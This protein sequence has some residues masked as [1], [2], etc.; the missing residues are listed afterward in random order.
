MDGIY[1]G[2]DIGSSTV[3]VV[4]LISENNTLNISSYLSYEHFNN[5]L[6]KLQII[7]QQ[8]R[9]KPVL[10]IQ[11]TGLMS[12]L[13]KLP[14]IPIKYARLKGFN[15]LYKLNNCVI[16]SFGHKSNSILEIV[17]DRLSRYEENYKC[18]QGSG[19]F[20]QSMLS[21]FNTPI[22][23]INLE[24]FEGER[25]LNL[26]GRCPVLLKS[27]ITHLHN[28]GES[29]KAILA[30]LLDIISENL[31]INY[32]P[33]PKINYALLTGGIS[34]VLRIRNNICS[35]LKTHNIQLISENE[36]DYFLDAFGCALNAFEKG[37]VEINLNSDL[38]NNEFIHWDKTPALS[39]YLGKVK[40][41]QPPQN[42]IIS[43]SDSFIAGLDIGST[44]SKLVL[45]EYDTQ[46]II[47]EDYVKTNGEPLNAVKRLLHNLS[48]HSNIGTKIICF[49]VTGSGRFLIESILKNLFGPGQVFVFNEIVAHAKGALYYDSAVDTIFEIGGQDSKYIRLSNGAI[50]D[51]AL[52]DACSAGT[53]S[54]LEELC[55]R[56]SDY[57][58]LKCLN[59][60]VLNA[61][62]GI[63]L[64]Q[65]CSVFISDVIERAIASGCSKESLAVGL[66]DSVIINYL[67][68]VKKN[69]TIGKK[70][71]CQ[72]MPFSMEALACSVARQT[73]CEIIIPNNPGTI[74][75]LGA[76]LLAKSTITNDKKKYLN[77]DLIFNV[78]YLAKDNF[79]CK[80]N[81][82]CTQ[83]G[84]R[85]L[86]E[87][88]IIKQ[89][90]KVEELYWGGNCA[91]WDKQSKKTI[92]SNYPN[93]FLQ[94][95]QLIERIKNNLKI[96]QE[97]KTVAITDKFDLVELFP[98]FSSFFSNLGFNIIT[99][100]DRPESLLSE[101]KK[102][103]NV[104]LCSPA[105]M[106]IGE[107]H[108]LIKKNPDYLF[109]PIFI[110]S[111][112][113]LNNKK[114]SNCPIVQCNSYLIK[115]SINGNHKSHILTPIIRIGKE[116]IYSKEFYDSCK[117]ITGSMGISGTRIDK[118]YK[119]AIEVQKNFFSDCLEI[120][121][122]AI[123]YCRDHNII[124]VIVLGKIYSLHNKY[125]NSNVPDYLRELDVIPIP[126]DCYR[127]EAASIDFS[128]IYWGYAQQ[129]LMA[130]DQ[131][132]KQPDLFS[133]FC[134]NYSC[135]PDSFLESYYNYIMDEKPS[136]IIENDGDSG[137]I[138]T[139][140][141][142]EIFLHCINEHK[143]NKQKKSEKDISAIFKNTNVKLAQLL[144]SDDRILLP[145]IGYSSNAVAAVLRGSGIKCEALPKPDSEAL[146]LGKRF[147][148]GKE[149]LPM[150]I[151]IG[152]L[153]HYIY[154]NKLLEQNNKIYYF[155]PG[156][157]G[158]CRFG[159]YQI[160]DKLILN[161]LGLQEKVYI[162]STGDDELFEGM[163]SS[164]NAIIYLALIS[165]DNLV[166]C[167]DFVR[168]VENKS[169]DTNKLFNYYY[170]M[171]I[172]K[173]ENINC[174]NISDK[175]LIVEILTRNL[176]G[177]AKLFEDVAQDYSKLKTSRK[178]KT[179]S[180]DGALYVR[181]DSFTNQNIA[182]KLESLGLRIK[183]VPFTE[184]LDFLNTFN[185]NEH[186]KNGIKNLFNDYLRKT[187]R[188]I[189]NSILHKNLGM[190]KFP[191]LESKLKEISPF[192][193]SESVG[194]AILSIG[195]SMVL[196]K[197]SRIDGIINICPFECLQCKVAD[198]I[199]K[200]SS[201]DII[202]KSIEFN[203]D[204][205]NPNLI[206]DFVFDVEN[207]R[208][209]L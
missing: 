114:T 161:N 82:G 178:V 132:S 80:S 10:G 65:H 187:I 136:L 170:S 134:S 143:K 199:V 174:F 86:I 124:P 203:E 140:T 20:L 71:F 89:K 1:L 9:T 149:C 208:K 90:E 99:L 8:E 139:K 31:L 39:E 28:N 79:L 176:F 177:F 12:D 165:I 106:N 194:E 69:R 16:I 50:T 7:F 135:G 133:A 146:A 160:L 184:W 166:A 153:L 35:L 84:N 147:T 96:I 3:K 141:R 162:L 105:L 197:K 48:V 175:K 202:T 68:R 52:N 74:G 26:P 204:P 198:S 138:G 122:Y 182:Q 42:D 29:K 129:V 25:R 207:N 159:N 185:D 188:T 56:F 58:D 70:I 168:P 112:N 171:I 154:K 100:E 63:N 125:L 14:S 118:A 43:K 27:S 60:T 18:A 55:T 54:F 78:D 128:E 33:N 181:L 61:E 151:T 19:S 186:H 46:N 95:K 83:Q 111:I 102:H 49:A 97:G 22:H 5:P 196:N 191:E 98:F 130:S 51:F 66:F 23:K 173:L 156:S 167:T 85:C 209:V 157:N 57:F 201:T 193:G 127:L 113:Y 87:K 131:I 163:P 38:L 11:V 93:P 81:V 108:S 109:K 120:G 6:N 126:M 123:K 36:Q 15:Y 189:P 179:I 32:I 76:S 91:L 62:N 45:I 115:N 121:D 180:L 169:G 21:R 104:T 88:V 24:N 119:D 17:D 2:I 75:A 73:G 40:R 34:K 192:I 206:T 200:N 13:I 144:G 41:L 183:H 53:G 137:N 148:S 44:G 92:S 142:L 164:L 195:S 150:S 67:N 116:N 77:I 101:G 64:G 158:P 4:E 59:N 145:Y 107:I 47:Y 172:H 205:I 37:P 103:S 94:R 152:N 155:M 110:N 72:G 117:R 30:A 190:P